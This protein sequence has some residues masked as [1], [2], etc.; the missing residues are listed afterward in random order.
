MFEWLW[1]FIDIMTKVVILALPV[2]VAG[3]YVWDRYIQKQHSIL[4]THPVIG[5]L[6]Y[7]F[8][9]LGPELRQYFIWG[10]KEGKPID[11]DTQGYIAKAGKYGS[12][13]IGFGSRKDFSQEGFFLNNSMFPKNMNELAVDQ[14]KP[15]TTTYK[16]QIMSEGMISR[17]EKRFQTSSNPW[18]LQD[19]H[20]VV[21][22][23]YNQVP[24][25]YKTKG[26]IGISAMSFGS[27]SDHA[28]MALAQGAAIATGT[29]MNT[30]EGGLAPYHLSKVYEMLEHTH[31]TPVQP[32]ELIVYD[33]IKKRKL[34]SNFEILKELAHIEY[35]SMDVFAMEDHPYILAV[36]RLAASGYL[37][38]KETDLIYQIGSA[39]NGSRSDA[40]GTFDEAEFLRTA[41]RAEVKL[42]ELKLAQGAKV[43]GGKLPKSKL[44]PMIRKIR[45]IP[46]DWNYDVESPN[47]FTDF[48]DIPSLFD[49]I[50]KLRRISGKPV[51]IKVVAGSEHAI[52]E[53]AA[54]MQE[55]GQ[56]PDFI[57]VD[58]GEGGTGATYMEMADSL[59]LP[60]YSA[61]LIIDN[62]L[63]Q[64][65]V[66]D[67]VKVFASGMLATADKMAIAFSFGADLVNV[68]R[69]AMNTIG[70]INALKCNTN[71]CPTGVTS[72]KPE[73]KQGLVVEEKRFRT[74][75]YLATLREGVFMLGASCGL[76]SPVLFERSH[77]TFKDKNA[78]ATRM[79]KLSPLP[80]EVAFPPIHAVKSS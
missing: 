5:R 39:K 24:E 21:I 35:D 42:I 68:A 10:D 18:L 47:R 56:A 4:K 67:R 69:A 74:A 26:F 59:G 61:I 78:L 3:V 70:C 17:K 53:M 25:P 22:G 14:S 73:L 30:G 62:T 71:E 1:T 52:E 54:Y 8:E 19:Q 31:Q 55:T 2:G 45:G 7:V 75:N 33:F 28:V 13:V 29:W 57:T 23:E 65:G 32:D 46:M 80:V 16:Y 44:T 34:V 15:I 66:R 36:N 49:F 40:I 51:G 12:T 27:L 9:M 38:K 60:L 63:R 43:R 37:L 11:R 48:N 58:G 79:D 41:G 76:E 20:A 64:Y 6:R 50:A 72:H 77:V